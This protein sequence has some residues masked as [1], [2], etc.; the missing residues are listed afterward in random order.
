VTYRSSCRGDE[1][2]AVS[3]PRVWLRVALL[4][5]VYTGVSSVLGLVL[6]IPWLGPAGVLI[7]WSTSIAAD[8]VFVIG[9]IGA[10]VAGV[11]LAKTTRGSIGL[12]AVITWLTYGISAELALGAFGALGNGGSSPPDSFPSLGIVLV[13]APLLGLSGVAFAAIAPALMRERVKLLLTAGP[14]RQT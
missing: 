13:D 6:L 12:A 5:A 14:G 9:S 3:R 1:A 7:V 4:L 11:T 2:Q 10:V 8:V